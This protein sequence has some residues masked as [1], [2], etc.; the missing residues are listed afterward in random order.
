MNFGKDFVADQNLT[1]PKDDF[2]SYLNCP[3]RG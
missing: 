3:C 1:R 2:S